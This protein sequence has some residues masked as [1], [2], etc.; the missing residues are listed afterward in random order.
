MTAAKYCRGSTYT[1]DTRAIYGAAPSVATIRRVWCAVSRR[2][3]ATIRSL[4]QETHTATSSVGAALRILKGA[5][6]I[7]FEVGE[8]CARVVVVPLLVSAEIRTV[9]VRRQERAA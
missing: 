9:Y 3:D 1:R 4:A 2:P 7:Q 6:Y 5:G 8:N